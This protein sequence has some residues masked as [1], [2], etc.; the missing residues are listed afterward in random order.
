MLKIFIAL[1]A[2]AFVQNALATPLPDV[3]GNREA[4][5]GDFNRTNTYHW[6]RYH[7]VDEPVVQPAVTTVA[8]ER[9]SLLDS[10]PIVGPLLS[11]LPVV[12]PRE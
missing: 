12:G 9:P 2:V 1:T 3:V 5:D 6:H 8:V 7:R 11:G 4:T 10:I